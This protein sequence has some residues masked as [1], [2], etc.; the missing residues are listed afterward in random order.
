MVEIHGLAVGDR[1]TVTYEKRNY[2][3]VVHDIPAADTIIISHPSNQGVFLNIPDGNHADVS[4]IKDNA[5]MSFQV[6]QGLRRV[7]DNVPLLTLT[8]IT[9]VTRK[10]RRDY[11]RLDKTLPVQVA[12]KQDSPDE[13]P[14][15]MKGQAIN[16][17]GSGVK[18]AIRQPLDTDKKVECKITLS[19]DI[20]VVLNGEVVWSEKANQFTTNNHVGIRF[21]VEDEMT[22]RTLVRYITIEQRKK[23]KANHNT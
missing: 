3:S 19:P 18:L 21:T 1:V 17:S 9:P 5:M 16:I 7:K 2:E 4:F 22:Q 11:Y 10:Q 8:A 12:V 23:L 6:T 14:V 20:E 13:K 15:V